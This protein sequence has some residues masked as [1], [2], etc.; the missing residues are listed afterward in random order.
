MDYSRKVEK[1]VDVYL[2]WML[3]TDQDAGWHQPKDYRGDV[4]MPGGGGYDQADV[5]M[6]NEIRWLQNPHALLPLA[7]QL[8][9]RLTPKHRTPLIV[10]ARYAGT[11]NAETGRY[12]TEGTIARELGIRLHQCRER[13]RHAAIKLAGWLRELEGRQ[14]EEKEGEAA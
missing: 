6:I 3:S 7:R 9:G 10:H 4:R 12:W 5:K 11:I 8:I 1:L 14:D 2:S 13:R